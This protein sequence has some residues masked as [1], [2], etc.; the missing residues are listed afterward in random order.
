MFVWLAPQLLLGTCQSSVCATSYLPITP[1]TRCQV[2]AKLA[3]KC[4]RMWSVGARPVQCVGAP[5]LQIAILFIQAGFCLCCRFDVALKLRNQPV[6]PSISFSP[7]ATARVSLLPAVSCRVAPSW[8]HS[9]GRWFCLVALR[10]GRLVFAFGCLTLAFCAPR[11]A[12]RA[13]ASSLPAEP[14]LL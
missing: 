14:R 9:L 13:P 3:S 6:A 11:N 7:C 8:P 4:L 2:R 1:V 5:N 10:L 12:C